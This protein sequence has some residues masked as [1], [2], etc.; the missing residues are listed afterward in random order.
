MVRKS[1]FL[2]LALGMGA[3]S[4]TFL[5]FTPLE[6]A[7]ACA[8]WGTY[9]NGRGAWGGNGGWWGD[10]RSDWYGE[11]GTPEE[12]DY[13][14]NYTTP[15][16]CHYRRPHRYYSKNQFPYHGQYYSDNVDGAGLYINIR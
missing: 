3:L 13:F 8:R 1:T 10:S 11:Y 12:Y 15:N 16:Y 2:S 5:D 14:G 6:A 9:N 7:R 4:L